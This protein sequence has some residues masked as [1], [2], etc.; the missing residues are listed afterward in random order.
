MQQETG[1]KAYPSCPLVY[2]GWLGEMYGEEM[3]LG[4]DMIR[5]CLAGV[6]TLGLLGCGAVPENLPEN[7]GAE[8]PEPMLSSEAPEENFRENSKENS[9]ENSKEISRED[10]GEN[11]EENSGETS[12]EMSGESVFADTEETGAPEENNAPTVDS[13]EG[14]GVKLTFSLTGEAGTAKLPKEVQEQIK[15]I[16]EG[17]PPETAVGLEELKDYYALVAT[18]T[19]AGKEEETGEETTGKGRLTLYIP[20]LIEGLEN[21]SILYYENAAEE[22]K[23]LPVEGM[24]MEAK[25]VSMILPGSGTLTVIYKR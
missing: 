22:W 12:G 10:S 21:I 17:E 9:R 16:N 25:T 20:N 4:K 6:M 24:D 23:I 2:S 15:A 1:R 3:R 18:Y 5:S 8:T 19:V 13:A 7:S 11:S 14:E